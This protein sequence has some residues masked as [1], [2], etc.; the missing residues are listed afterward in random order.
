ME[1]MAIEHI[2]EDRKVGAV[3]ICMRASV[4]A[5]RVPDDFV[6]PGTLIAQDSREL[7]AAASKL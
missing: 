1:L 3:V 6:I 7:R 4:S 5:V 2:R